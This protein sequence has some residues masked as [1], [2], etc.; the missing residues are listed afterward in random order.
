MREERSVVLVLLALFV[1]FV[2][3]VPTKPLVPLQLLF[4]IESGDSQLAE[5]HS[6]DIHQHDT[7]KIKQIKS[8]GAP[9]IF[10][11]SAQRVVAE[12]TNQYQKGIADRIGKYIGKQTP[13]L[14]TQDRRLVKAQVGV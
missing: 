13:N 7:A 4:G 10:Q 9:A 8:E 1:A 12:Q 6:E 2:L 14:T 3:F 5:D 11:S